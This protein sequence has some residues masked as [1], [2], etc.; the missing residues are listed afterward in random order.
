ML[1]IAFLAVGLMLFSTFY[2]PPLEGEKTPDQ[3][4]DF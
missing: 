4:R 1:I 2:I 3:E